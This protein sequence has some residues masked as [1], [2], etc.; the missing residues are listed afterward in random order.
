MHN[1]QLT[2]LPESIGNLTSLNYLSVYNNKLTS[3]PES[4]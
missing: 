4:I 2:S 3:L 1:N